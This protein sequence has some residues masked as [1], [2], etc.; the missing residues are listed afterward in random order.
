MDSRLTL[1]K[2]L[3]LV[4]RYK[5]PK[6]NTEFQR[7]YVTH[8]QKPQPLSFNGLLTVQYMIKHEINVKKCLFLSQVN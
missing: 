1:L 5:T 7:F 3:D 6:S 2:P 8:P 4:K